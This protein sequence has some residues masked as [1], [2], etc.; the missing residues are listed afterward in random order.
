[1]S[2]FS[3][4]ESVRLRLTYSAEDL[5][6]L[7]VTLVGSALHCGTDNLVVFSL[8]NETRFEC[9]AGDEILRVECRFH[10]V[11]GQ[12]ERDQCVYQC[13]CFNRAPCEIDL[14]IFSY[15]EDRKFCDAIKN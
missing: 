3:N 8:R 5:K 11:T 12:D 13:P 10:G 14:I 7:N 1:M 9:G 6:L 15:S 2:D 4:E